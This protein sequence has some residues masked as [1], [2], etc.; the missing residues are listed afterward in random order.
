MKTNMRDIKKNLLDLLRC[1]T[2]IPD[3]N[4]YPF[5]LLSVRFNA[6]FRLSAEHSSSDDSL[7]D[8][9]SPGSSF[10]SKFPKI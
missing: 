7:L 3:R 8:I 5:I 1:S 10:L 4:T 2:K 9:F 6:I